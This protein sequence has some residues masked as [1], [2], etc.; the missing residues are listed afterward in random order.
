MS[1]LEDLGGT[2]AKVMPAEG[3][4]QRDRRATTEYHTISIAIIKMCNAFGSPPLHRPLCFCPTTYHNSVAVASRSRRQRVTCPVASQSL[5][6][7]TS[8]PCA[9]DTARKQPAHLEAS[10]SYHS[11]IPPDQ[12]LDIIAI[13]I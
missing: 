4:H 6:P 12:Q 10:A 5:T 11:P 7:T 3:L 13:N 9:V 8:T 2:G 1:F